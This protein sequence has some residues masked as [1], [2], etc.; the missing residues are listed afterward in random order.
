MQSNGMA[1]SC[2][3]YPPPDP[4]RILTVF[5]LL[6][7]D[8]KKGN[9]AAREEVALVLRDGDL[10]TSEGQHSAGILIRKVAGSGM[11]SGT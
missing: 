8:R 9:C 4:L 6:T 1:Q 3:C 7:E 10:C 11:G 5:G 2:I